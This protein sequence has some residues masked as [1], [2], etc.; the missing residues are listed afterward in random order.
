MGF[1]RPTNRDKQLCKPLIRLFQNTQAIKQILESL[2]KLLM[3]KNERKA[4]TLE[5][6]VYSIVT[7]DRQHR[8]YVP[9]AAYDPIFWSHHAMIDRLFWL[10][11]PNPSHSLPLYLYDVVL[12]PF[13]GNAASVKQVLNIYQFGYDYASQQ[14][15]VEM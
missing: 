9:L 15:L 12:D 5:A 2:S 3:E 14:V 8:S 1:L 11:Q 7:G 10:W 6:R 4:N 13:G